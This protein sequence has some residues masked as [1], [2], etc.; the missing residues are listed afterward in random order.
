MI[1]IERNFRTT[2]ASAVR[3]AVKERPWV[4][5]IAADKYRVVPRK[6]RDGSREHG[7]YVVRFTLDDGL[8]AE[9]V[10]VV[11]GE[12]CPAHQFERICYHV[13]AALIHSERLGRKSER[14]AA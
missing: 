10:N 3:K 12:E 14:K 8:W 5:R 2:Y 1:A 13:G 11:T 4:H 9:C 6:L 7:K